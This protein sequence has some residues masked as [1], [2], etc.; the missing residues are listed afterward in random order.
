MLGK[1]GLSDT[2]NN[3]KHKK[4]IPRHNIISKPIECSTPQWMCLNQ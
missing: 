2:K 3:K 1:C 4:V